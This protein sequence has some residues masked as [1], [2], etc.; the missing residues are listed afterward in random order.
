[1]ARVRRWRGY[2]P[3][4]GRLTIIRLSDQMGWI[5]L[6]MACYDDGGAML[7]SDVGRLTKQPVGMPTCRDAML[8][9]SSP[10]GFNINFTLNT[11]F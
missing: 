9:V 10:L 6:S 2:A 1:M 3:D 5:D 8:C 7:L 11:W 4:V